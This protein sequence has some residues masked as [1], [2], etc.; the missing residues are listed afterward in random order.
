MLQSE[1][2]EKERESV[3]VVKED[4]IVGKYSTCERNEKCIQTIARRT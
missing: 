4:N 3:C 1:S 2:N